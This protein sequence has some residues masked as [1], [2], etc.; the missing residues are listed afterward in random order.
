MNTRA[1]IKRC[2]H[3]QSVECLL[4]CILHVHN[5]N[6]CVFSMCIHPP[7]PEYTQLQCLTKSTPTE[8][9]RRKK[10]QQH[11]CTQCTSADPNRQNAHETNVRINIEHTNTEQCVAYRRRC[12]PVKTQ[13]N[14]H[15]YACHHY[16]TV[17]LYT[18]CT[19]KI[20]Y[21]AKPPT[22]THL[23]R[24]HFWMDLS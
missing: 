11:M 17:L 4:A 3:D 6:I 18:W 21:T 24:A 1:I 14:H 8:K 7:S 16:Y 15:T 2:A 5:A 23:P 9:R 10:K 22:E 20:H 19:C 12:L 13:S